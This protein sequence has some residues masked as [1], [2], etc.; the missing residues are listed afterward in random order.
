[1]GL[2]AKIILIVVV[3]ILFA[4]VPYFLW[5]FPISTGKRVGNL[6][7]ISYKGKFT[8]TKTWEGTIDEGSGD[9]LTS[10][11]SVRNK[12]VANELFN[13]KG[14]AVVIF[15]E[16]YLVNWPWETNYN[17]ISWEPREIETSGVMSSFQGGGASSA[18][19]KQLELSLF[20]SALGSLYQNQELYQQVKD[21]LKKTNLYIYKQ[22]EKCN[23]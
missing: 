5:N 7:K 3:M 23:E 8:F 19:V 2:K 20:C 13:Y 1:M 18:A 21:Y 11:F 16:E 15:Y 9:K 4:G 22:I 14:K 17:V 6:V 12:D 10:Y